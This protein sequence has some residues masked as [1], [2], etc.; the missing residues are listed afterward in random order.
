MKKTLGIL[1]H[2]DAGKTTFSEQLLYHTGSIRSLGRV[3]HKTSYMDTDEIERKRGITIFADQ[4][5]FNYGEDTYY[6]ID[7]P[8]HVDFSAETERA[9]CALD[10]AILLINGSSGVQ[11]HTTTLFRLLRSYKIPTFLFINK[12]DINDFNL[13]TTLD[14]IKNKLTS[15][16]LYIEST[17]DILNINQVVA[18]FGAERDENFLEAY[19]KE[20][21]T[22]DYMQKTIIDLIKEQQCFPVMSGSALKG[23][24][25]DTFLEV[26]SKL[27]LTSYEDEENSSFVGKVH[28]IRYDDKGNRL[29][30]I[31][32]LS[33]KLQVKDEFT[34]EKDGQIY[35]EKVN[36]IRIYNGQKYESKNM[37]SGGDVFAVTGF[38]T[39]ICG[40][41]LECGKIKSELSESYYLVP[42]LQSKINILD[43]TD[44]AV[45][46]ENL[47][48]LEAEDPMLSVSFQR[49]SEQILV[50]V[51][52]YNRY[53]VLY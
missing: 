4:G 52:G 34:F 26:F 5:I 20:D 19:L 16:I 38:K 15:D 50:N 35:G 31:K 48:L 25:I 33:G 37:V 22:V 44:S 23:E 10:Y 9:I 41:I 2:V 1:A 3:D 47:R 29:T 30:F 18:E 24:G 49:E 17:K 40:T 21:Y 6:I 11:A 39:P 51:M 53:I 45:F 14:D 7:T 27:S 32:A 46:M 36:E 8:G 42:T 13:E 43:G 12:T 28:K